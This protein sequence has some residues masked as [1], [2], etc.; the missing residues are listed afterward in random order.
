MERLARMEEAAQGRLAG[1]VAGAPGV[2]P[3]SAATPDASVRP[4]ASLD[5]GDG[6]EAPVRV[7][8]RPSPATAYVAADTGG[9]DGADAPAVVADAPDIPVPAADPV[10]RTV[11]IAASDPPPADP[12]NPPYFSNPA[13]PSLSTARYPLGAV[14]P[15][16]FPRQPRL[17]P[18]QVAM[19]Q[20]QAPPPPPPNQGLPP[21][22]FDQ[23]FQD[24]RGGVGVPSSVPP[25]E[26][27][28]V[29]DPADF[30]EIDAQAGP[31]RTSVADR[32]DALGGPAQIAMANPPPPRG[33]P[34]DRVALALAAQK[35]QAQQ[36][37]QA[38]AQQ[39]VMGG[40]RGAQMP[41][42]ASLGREG[43]VSDA[44]TPGVT[45]RGVAESAA[46][47]EAVTRALL[48]QQAPAPTPAP[49]VPSPDPTSGASSPPTTSA[50]ASISEGLRLLRF[51]LARCDSSWARSSRRR[52]RSTRRR[53]SRPPAPPVARRP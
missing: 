53:R 39:D 42:T 23:T 51:R 43:V 4:Q 29:A 40:Y 24:T 27:V 21:V 50:P 48:Q 19:S 7:S 36:I 3:T 13:R 52:P 1:Q 47:R 49:A 22:S 11:Q 44:P 5:T 30:N 2:A 17:L 9:G 32:F 38:Q 20:Q 31:D 8:A 6:D 41:R 12:A 26:E 33:D 16:A 28:A 15:Q 45:E 25:R 37:A 14:P 34:R 35:E 46:A 10:A 18:G